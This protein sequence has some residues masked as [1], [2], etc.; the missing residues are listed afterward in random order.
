MTRNLRLTEAQLIEFRLPKA[1]GGGSG[2]GGGGSFYRGGEILTCTIC[3]KE[4]GGYAVRIGSDNLPGFLQTESEHEVGM[5]LRVQF[6]CIHRN[7]LRLSEATADKS[8]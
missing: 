1:A 7:R 2:S 8:Y 3:Q 4:P 5:E 6:V